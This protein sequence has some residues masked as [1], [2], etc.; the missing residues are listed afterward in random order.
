MRSAGARTE[1]L[2]VVEAAELFGVVLGENE[3]LL[4]LRFGNHQPVSNKLRAA[5]R[6]YENLA[7]ELAIEQLLIVTLEYEDGRILGTTTFKLGLSDSAR[8]L[9]VNKP[10]P[11]DM[12]SSDLPQYARL[13]DA[14]ELPGGA[15]SLE[16]FDS[17]TA[18]LRISS[19]DEGTGEI[20]L[21]VRRDGLASIERVALR[22]GVFFVVAERT[23]SLDSIR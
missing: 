15:W 22:N 11:N 19:S 12:S 23:S 13:G 10:T 9:F 8:I 17:Q 1:T 14:G 3:S 20:C 4:R 5:A 2:R 18:R 21:L 6:P 16:P 7:R